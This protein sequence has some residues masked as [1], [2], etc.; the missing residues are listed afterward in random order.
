MSSPKTQMEQANSDL[1]II[2]QSNG[3][4]DVIKQEDSVSSNQ[5]IE[6]PLWDV[7]GNNVKKIASPTNR[8]PKSFGYQSNKSKNRIHQRNLRERRRGTG[9]AHENNETEDS[10]DEDDLID[11]IRIAKKISKFNEIFS[12]D[13]IESSDDNLAIL[14]KQLQKQMELKDAYIQGL[15]LKIRVL[16]REL[17]RKEK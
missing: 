16:E 10:S 5:K 14:C 13:P 11:S 17:S 15:E 1:K 12:A 4:P 3:N 2:D 6:K 9:V 8:F 7:T